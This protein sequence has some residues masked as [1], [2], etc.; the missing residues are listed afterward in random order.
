MRGR[1]PHH[2]ERNLRRSQTEAERT[3]WQHLRDRRL[4]GYKFRRQHRI[5][6][7]YPDFV[8]LQARLIIELDGSQH[9][10][11]QH[12]DE[13]RTRRL[14]RLGYR[15]LRLWNDD[16]LLR[17]DDALAAIAASLAAPHP[18]RRDTFSP[19]RGEKE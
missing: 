14:E 2:R 16:V 15:V 13:T 8:C 18:S 19:Q 17:T 1:H 6:R 3:L 12:Y 4:L 5:D 9:Q 10:D 11:R 7:F